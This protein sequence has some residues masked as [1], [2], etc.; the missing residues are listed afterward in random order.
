M[1]APDWFVDNVTT[2]LFDVAGNAENTYN[3]C[4]NVARYQTDFM[5]TQSGP[6]D[7]N[8][9]RMEETEANVIEACVEVL[10]DPDRL[11]HILKNKSP[12]NVL[13]YQGPLNR[14]GL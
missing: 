6:L 1:T 8:Y 2:K 14:D 4:M 12:S 9:W 7:D 3:V 10:F 13:V 5:N 11:K